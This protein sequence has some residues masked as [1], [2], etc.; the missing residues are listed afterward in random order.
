MSMQETSNPTVYATLSGEGSGILDMAGIKETLTGTDR[1]DVRRI[2]V[3]KV[4]SRARM[5]GRAVVLVTDDELGVA[6]LLIPADG[7]VSKIQL[8]CPPV[9]PAPAPIPAVAEHTTIPGWTQPAPAP[10]APLP[11]SS[12][13]AQPAPAQPAPAQESVEIATEPPVSERRAARASFL[14]QEAPLQPATTGWRGA[15]TR[16]GMKIS[17]SERELAE[18]ADV[19]AVSRHWNGPRTI[20]IVNGKGGANKTPTTAILA[21]LFA[22]YGGSGVL[23]WDNNETRGTLGWRTE[24]AGHDCTV[25][26]LLPQT[27]Y[28]LG[29]GAQSSELSHYV[30]HQT[31]DKYDVLRSNPKAV[32]AD[33]KISRA[34]FAEL[35]RVATKYFRLVFID[36]GNDESAERWQQMIDQTD[37]LVVATTALGEHAEAGALLLEDLS[38][39]DEHAAKLVRGAVVIVSQSE[40]NGSLAAA[41]LIA[42]GFNGLACKAASIPFDEALHGGKIHFDALSATAQRA[43]LAAAAAV[44]EGL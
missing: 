4:A 9:L 20:A 15:L 33:Q 28:L 29:P 26:D 30:H 43:W 27:D 13:Q 42:E 5:L 23:A 39:R 19:H 37:Q 24:Q 11:A 1:N 41:Q 34:E 6:E 10:P 38:R 18:R 35:H 3:A 8:V 32:S 44:A 25:Q 22:R 16:V 2:I 17:P 21:A 40:K 12:R 7:D 36:S 31:G 14:D